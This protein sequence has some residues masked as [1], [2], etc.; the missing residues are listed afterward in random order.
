MACLDK[1][2][3][4]CRARIVNCEMDDGSAECD[5][6]KRRLCRDCHDG[7][8]AVRAAADTPVEE[9]HRACP[10][11]TGLRQRNEDLLAFARARFGAAWF[12]QLRAAYT[13]AHPAPRGFTYGW[14]QDDATEAPGHGCA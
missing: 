11:C 14:Q 2:C 9:W 4:G 7:D 13:A 1:I 6:C 10:Y 3:G 5:V 12:D 8:W